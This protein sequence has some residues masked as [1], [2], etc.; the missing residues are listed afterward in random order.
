LWIVNGCKASPDLVT[1]LTGTTM[2]TFYQIS[3]VSAPTGVNQVQLEQK[4]QDL[5]EQINNWMSTYRE[6]SELSHFNRATTTDWVP[7]SDATCYTVATAL[8]ISTLTRG[9]FDVTVAPLVDL[10]GFGPDAPPAQRPDKQA[11]AG[12]MHDV[13]YQ[14]LHTRSQP[15]ALRKDHPGL[16]VDLSGI[17]KGYAVD[18]VADLLQQQ[19]IV[20]YLVEI[21]GEI[22]VKGVKP[23]GQSWRIAIEQPRINGSQMQAV[24]QL[25]DAAVATSGDYRNFLRL[26]GTRYTH[27]I[28][29]A[30]GEP[31]D[32]DLAS[33]TLVGE[34][35][36]KMDALATA[37]LAMGT[38]R[39]H[40]FALKH[41][42][43]ALLITRK[44][45]QFWVLTTPEM[46]TYLVATAKQPKQ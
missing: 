26:Q 17:A 42:L 3:I 34:S 9:W 35:T 21:G 40:E 30:T 6:D 23:T 33:V 14:W 11:L 27:I 25:G 29:P 45:G 38:Q 7:V 8:E 2:G 41:Q 18:R 31:V 13:G 12:L 16:A 28:D 32:H 44:N 46:Q 20:N 24:L 1:H 4:I 37:L 5:L 36:I 22:R 19:G 39:A 10:W 43:A 15:P